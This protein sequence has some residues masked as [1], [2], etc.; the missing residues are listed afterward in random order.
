M[1]ICTKR[2]LAEALLRGSGS[3]HETAERLM[4][5]RRKFGINPSWISSLTSDGWSMGQNINSKSANKTCHF[6]VYVQNHKR[7][8]I[9]HAEGK[10]CT[11]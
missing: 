10:S 6:I 11:G 2:I 9:R 8:F 7:P 3:S 5:E 1:L 4:G